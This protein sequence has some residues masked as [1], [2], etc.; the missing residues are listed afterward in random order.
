MKKML[1]VLA[2]IVLAVGVT[3]AQVNRGRLAPVQENVLG[4]IGNC[5]LPVPGGSYIIDG[6]DT[7]PPGGSWGGQS[8]STFAVAWQKGQVDF[9]TM[10]GRFAMC[11]IP[12]VFGKTPKKIEIKWLMG[13][14][15]DS[16]CIFASVA[17]G[18]LLV[19]CVNET[20]LSEVWQTDTWDL[21][22]GAFASGQDVTVKILVTGNAWPS[23]NTYGQLAVDYIK[24]IGE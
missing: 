19:K 22:A 9:P 11:T 24:I 20:S 10:A 2:V 5:D 21:P 15:N 23:F 17:A 7:S 14:A 18:D 13:L 12:G 3:S 16:H 8:T 4:T 6:W 1:I